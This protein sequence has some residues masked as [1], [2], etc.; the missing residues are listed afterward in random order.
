MAVHL[1][2][3][4]MDDGA[5]EVVVGQPMRSGRPPI[6]LEKVANTPAGGRMAAMSAAGAAHR[7]DYIIL[8]KVG[9]PAVKIVLAHAK[10]FKTLSRLW[11][12][13][14]AEGVED[15]GISVAEISAA[16]TEAGEPLATSS[17]SAA[18]RAMVRN[19]AVRSAESFVGRIGRRPRYYPL[20]FGHTAF[21]LAEVIGDG[22][23][24]QVGRTVKAWQSRSE[25]EPSNL[26]QHASLIRGYA[27][28]AE[29][30]SAESA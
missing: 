8:R 22:S 2:P 11:G 26:F 1:D 3:H 5:T 9:F 4:E 10:V 14:R 24:V 18:L 17:L 23:F 27:E 12:A 15:P 30:V 7:R 19:N 29:P 28:P 6:D 25:T 20:E 21:A 16:L 13:K